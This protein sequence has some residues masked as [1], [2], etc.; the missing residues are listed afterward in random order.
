[1]LNQ[2][3]CKVC[4][5]RL[6]HLCILQHRQLFHGEVAVEFRMV[7]QHLA[8]LDLIQGPRRLRDVVL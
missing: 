8:A 7:V 3:M 4:V 2:L 1:M 5:Y 6:L